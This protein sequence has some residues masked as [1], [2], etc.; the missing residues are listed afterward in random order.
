MRAL[1][2]SPQLLGTHRSL[3]AAGEVPDLFGECG[4]INSRLADGNSRAQAY[5]SQRI[6]A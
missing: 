4:Q 1:D 6:G 5:R 3:I 2:E